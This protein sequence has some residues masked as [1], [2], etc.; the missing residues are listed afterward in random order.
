MQARETQEKN[1]QLLIRKMQGTLRDMTRHLQTIG[2]NISDIGSCVDEDSSDEDEV[3]EYDENDK[4]DNDE[5]E[6][7]RILSLQLRPAKKSRK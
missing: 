2:D 1:R 6:S 7:D 4:N 5:E 3:D